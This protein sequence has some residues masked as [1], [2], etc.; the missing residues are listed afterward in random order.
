MALISLTDQDDTYDHTAGKEWS[1]IRGLGGN[2]VIFIHGNG[3]VTG[4]PGNDVITNDVFSGVAGGVS[5][6]GSPSEIYVDL[7]AGY[8]LDGYGTRDTL[9]NIRDINTSGHDG[10]VIFGTSK[11][12]WIWL[13]GFDWKLRSPGKATLDLRGGID[14]VGFW[15]VKVTDIRVE[16]SADAR[17]VNLFGKNGYTATLK[18]VETLNFREFFE[19]G[20]EVTTSFAVTDLIDLQSAAPSIILRGN[21]GWQSNAIG[22]PTSITYSFFD[23]APSLGSEGGTGFAEFTSA[24]QQTIRDIFFVLQNQTGLTFSEVTGDSGQIRFGVNQQKNTKGYSFIPDEFK[25]DARAGDVWLDQE[26][27]AVM[28]PGQEGYYVLLHELGHA[29]GLQHP[30]PESDTSGVTVLLNSFATTSNTLM[31]EL[32]PSAALDS[33][34]TWF[35]SFDVQALRYLYGKREF[36]A[37][38]DTYTVRDSSSDLTI[39][40]DGGIDT[41]DVSSVS[42][43]ARIDLR[44]GKS[45]SIGMDTDG[46]SK[47]NNVAITNGSYI[48]NVIGSPQDD[49]IIGNLQNNFITFTGGSDIVDGQAGID[50]VR[51]WNTSAEFKVFKESSTGYWYTEATNN[52]SGSIE[53]RNVERLFFS[54]TSWAIDFGELQNANITAKILGA[55]FG[56]ESVSNKNYVGIGLN[57]LDA[58]WTYDNLA[59]LALDA[60]GAKTNDQIVSLLWTN[61]IGTQPTTADKAP[62]IALLEKGMSAGA[63]AHL[64]ADSS[65]NTTNINLVGLAQNGIEYIPMS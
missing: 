29:L 20:L 46:T 5:Y 58:G 25:N 1:D 53:L 64:A 28:D 48:E 43:S 2:D 60:A 38:N 18:N 59:A 61:V 40:D 4:G 8:A 44:D 24:Q 33:W 15:N 9:V 19:N 31:L 42:M 12:D 32:N 52:T 62:Y 17:V 14:T 51:F 6:G 3:K 23:K 50:I 41:L 26:T 65:F 45:S 21:K 22:S 10:D 57:F 13:G 55:I 7:E 11:S 30:L 35:G 63:L 49:V 36:A 37:G 54:D 47:F 16:V 34:P 27:A 56:K 39:V